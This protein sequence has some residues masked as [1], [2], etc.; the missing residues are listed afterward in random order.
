ML[1][2]NFIPD[3]NRLLTKYALHHVLDNIYQIG[4]FPSKCAWKRI[5]F[6]NTIQQSN[7]ELFRECVDNYPACAT[8][9][10][11]SDGVS[12]I[13]TIT[14]HCKELLSICRRIMRIIGRVAMPKYRNT[15]SLCNRVNSDLVQHRILFCNTIDD[16]RIEL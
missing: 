14:R 4:V 3:I 13:W 7:S 2:L 1:S 6:E 15:C 10:L 9:I 12:C 5:S 16:C 11:R 8:L